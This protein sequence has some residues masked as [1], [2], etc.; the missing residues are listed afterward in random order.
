[1]PTGGLR[2]LVVLGGPSGESG[3]ESLA[4]EGLLFIPTPGKPLDEWSRTYKF[5]FGFHYPAP[6]AYFAQVD[7]AES[8]YRELQHDV[9][10]V[11]TLRERLGKAEADAATAQQAPAGAAQR[12]GPDPAALDAR[13][14]ELKTQLAQRKAEAAIKALRYYEVRRALDDA[15][16]AFVLTNPYTWRNLEGQAAFYQRWQTVE[17]HHPRIDELIA[18]LAALLPEP[19]QLERARSEAMAVFARNNN[20]D[21]NPA[22]KPRTKDSPKEQPSGGGSM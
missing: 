18:R 7:Q 9:P 2:Y 15:Y 5:D 21:K 17:F 8:L 6:P 11:E 13:A 16:A 19:K 22:P 14:R 4:Y 10:A 20:W 12:G 3:G 1:V